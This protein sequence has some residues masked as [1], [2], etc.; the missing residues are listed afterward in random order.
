VLF[1]DEPTNGVDPVS[2]R[3]FW[4]ILYQLV[5]EGV[6]IFV[7]TAYLDEAER[8]NR[9][10]LLHQ[11]RLLGVGTPDEIKAMMPGALLE[12]RTSAPRRTAA[13]LREQLAEGAV[14]LFGDRVH[15]ATRDAARAETHARELITAA[16][17]ELLSIRPIEPSLE[18]VFVSVVAQ[19]KEVAGAR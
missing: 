13:L 10:A 14:G 12:V 2:R 5:R 18:D 1:L 19:Q 17:F 9:L 11:G 8:C 3:D 6:T 15:L 16:G 7:S 4:R